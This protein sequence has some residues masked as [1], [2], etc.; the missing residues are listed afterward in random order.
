MELG[1]SVVDTAVVIT[2]VITVVADVATFGIVFVVGT[3]E[4]V[5]GE[6]RVGVV[7]GFATL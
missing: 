4:L 2:D 3:V 1:Q 7:R 6:T 5:S